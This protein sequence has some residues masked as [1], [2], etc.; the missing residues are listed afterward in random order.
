MHREVTN[1]KS[2]EKSHLVSLICI[3]SSTFYSCDMIS[4][5]ACRIL[6]ALCN[7]LDAGNAFDEVNS[8]IMSSSSAIL[9]HSRLGWVC[10]ILLFVWPSIK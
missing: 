2:G 10:V 7:L 9:Q 4:K 8:I 1:A 6:N 5:P 3:L